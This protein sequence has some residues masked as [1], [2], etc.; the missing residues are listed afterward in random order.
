MRSCQA[1]MSS[2]AAVVAMVNVRNISPAGS[3]Q[4]SHS[5]AK[6]NGAP[7]VRAIA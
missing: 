4:P 6:A 5:P 7:L 3:R 1:A 2:F